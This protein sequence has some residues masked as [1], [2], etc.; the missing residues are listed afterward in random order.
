MASLAIPKSMSFATNPSDASTRKMF[1]GFTS[2]WITPDSM[3]ELQGTRDV[4]D[5]GGRLVDRE[6]R[7]SRDAREQV[8]AAQELHREKG[9][10]I[11]GERAAVAVQDADH[12]G[13]THPG[14]DAG[15]TPEPLPRGRVRRHEWGQ[16]LHDDLHAERPVLGDPEV[17]HASLG[18]RA[19]QAKV[20]AQFEAFAQFHSGGCR[21]TCMPSSAAAAA[22]AWRPVRHEGFFSTN[23]PQNA[24]LGVL[25][26]GERA[27]TCAHLP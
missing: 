4:I 20:F 3:G 25:K 11:V 7:A 22:A 26:H 19:D 14:R 15:L 27:R 5:H 10:G 6:A 9:H 16:G 8:F 1:P 24:V 23:E 17:G 12:V 18:E 21:A 2:L 13:A